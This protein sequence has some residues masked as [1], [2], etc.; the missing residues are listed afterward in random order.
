MDVLIAKRICLSPIPS[1]ER[2]GNDI[3]LDHCRW[4]QP[5]DVLIGL[6]RM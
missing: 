6:V 2:G 1:L 3:V 5:T 4:L